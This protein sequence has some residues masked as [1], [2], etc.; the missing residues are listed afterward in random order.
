MD[1]PTVKIIADAFVTMFNCCKLSRC[2]NQEDTSGHNFLT[3]PPFS[4][5]NLEGVKIVRICMYC[6]KVMEDEVKG[7]A[8]VM[9]NLSRQSGMEDYAN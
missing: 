4:T 3:Y 9:G 7:L 5:A 8:K 6:G 2:T 1:S